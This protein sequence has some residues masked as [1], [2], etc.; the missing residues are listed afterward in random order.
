MP[1]SS[2]GF[3]SAGP[4]AASLDVQLELVGICILN[5][6]ILLSIHRTASVAHVDNAS[7]AKKPRPE[8]AGISAFP[9]SFAEG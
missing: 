3:G 7:Y 9:E 4:Q 5:S 2:F 6:R 1:R 8:L